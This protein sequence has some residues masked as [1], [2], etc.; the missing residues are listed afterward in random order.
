[1]VS[2][3]I[4]FNWLLGIWIRPFSFLFTGTSQ[5][6]PRPLPTA[7]NSPTISSLS[8][9][10]FNLMVS[11]S[12]GSIPGKLG[13]TGTWSPQTIPP[14]TCC[15]CKRCAKRF[16]ARRKLPLPPWPCR[17]RTLKGT[18]CEMSLLLQRCWIGSWLWTTIH[19]DVSFYFTFFG[20]FIF[21]FLVLIFDPIAY[22]CIAC[23]GF[24]GVGLDLAPSSTLS[25]M[26]NLH[27]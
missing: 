18:R 21:V 25:D 20:A 16:P 8:T 13:T 6:P 27:D 9:T 1:M 19:G 2:I 17:S 14:T 22:S 24:F 15:F 11:T 7:K 3:G 10:S 5:P 4:G 23:V 26:H 12:T